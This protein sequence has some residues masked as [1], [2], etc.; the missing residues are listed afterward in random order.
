MVHKCKYCG[1]VDC[2]PMYDLRKPKR[3]R[4]NVTNE[5]FCPVCKSH[6]ET[7]QTYMTPEEN[8]ARQPG[9][10][11]LHNDGGVYQPATAY[12]TIYICKHCNSEL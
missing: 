12:Y 1:H 2:P 8:D 3:K 10:P 5:L 11:C 4:Y 6:M 7:N 9:K